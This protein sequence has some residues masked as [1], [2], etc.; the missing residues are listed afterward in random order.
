MYPY[1][2]RGRPPICKRLGKYAK[3]PEHQA[4]PALCGRSWPGL[5]CPNLVL[6]RSVSVSMFFCLCASQPCRPSLFVCIP[7]LWP[8]SAVVTV[9]QC[10]SLCAPAVGRRCLCV[11]LACGRRCLLQAGVLVRRF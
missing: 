11:F 3:S 6:N 1:S 8:S 2:I 7:C 5:A 9:C 4:C 10:F